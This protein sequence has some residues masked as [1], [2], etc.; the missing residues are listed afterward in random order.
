[1]QDTSYNRRIARKIKSNDEQMIHQSDLLDSGYSGPMGGLRLQPVCH[2]CGCH[3]VGGMYSW[4][5]FKHD[6]SGAAKYVQPV[7]EPIVKALTSKA[8]ESIAGAGIQRRRRGKAH[9]EIHGG[10]KVGD[11]FKK[12]FT[13]PKT[14][15]KIGQVA[16]IGLSALGMPEVGVP[17]SAASGVLGSGLKKRK[18]R[19]AVQGGKYS[20]DDFKHDM[21]HGAQYIQPVAEPIIKALTSKAVSSIAGAGLKRQAKFVKGSQ[22]AKDHMAKI[23]AMKK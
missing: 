3:M 2:N 4:N 8:I 17:L 14:Y 15:A 20:W 7:A 21:S 23:R 19:K 22:A 5:D 13:N 1:M 10:N 12:T 16:G 9:D 18:P 11:W 6:M